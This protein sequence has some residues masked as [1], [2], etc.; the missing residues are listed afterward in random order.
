MAAGCGPSASPGPPPE[1]VLAQRFT[2][3]WAKG[4][5]QALGDM[6][7]TLSPAVASAQTRAAFIARYQGV[8]ERMALTGL[9]FRIGSPVESGAHASVPVAVRYVTTYAGAF[10]EDVR[11]NFTR[12]S[13]G[14]AID[15]AP[16]MILP[17]LAGDRH[18]REEH[19]PGHRGRILT[20]DGTE[21]AL[22]SDQG[23][24]V[25]VVR[26]DIKDE[27]AM[28]AAMSKLLS[29]SPEAIR[30][31]YQGGQPEWFMPVRALPPDTSLNLHNQLS[32]IPGVTVHQA[33]VRFYPQHRAAAQLVGYVSRAGEAQAGLE[34]TLDPVLAGH[35]GGRIFVVDG[36]ENDVGTV[37]QRA[38]APGRDVVLTISW[39]V[40]QAAERA[41]E[42]DPRDAVVAE[43]PRTGDI[44]AMA[45][46]PSFDPNDFA[47]TRND[48]IAGYNAEAASPLLNRATSGQYPSGSTFKPITAAAALRAGVVT[49]DERIPCPHLW[50][51]YG[52]PG[53]E[54]HE[55]ADLGPIDL[56]TAVA[57]SCNTYFYELGKRL[58][59]KAPNLLTD[60][61]RSFGLGA[62]THLPFVSEE[63]GKVPT[64]TAGGEAVNL[65]IGQGGLQVTP[66]QMADYTAA[67]AAAGVLPRPRVVLREEPRAGDVGTGT[68]SPSAAAATPAAAP[69]HALVRP[70]DLPVLLDAMRLVTQDPSG[71]LFAA[72]HGS[73]QVFGKSGTAETTAGNPDI[74][75]IGGAPLTGSS[76][77]V[78]VLV[79]EKP[80]GLH[81][82]DAA[83]IGRATLEAALRAPG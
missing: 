72:F 80:N 17:Q 50:T 28:L 54:N 57:R 13:R 4:D 67:L 53:Q 79:E 71:T 38:A 29:M 73:P 36:Q 22:S 12:G 31:A 62:P 40:Q 46:H 30:Q 58:F 81:T 14:W 39:P 55:S 43:D 70:Q 48:A 42:V 8:R 52:P 6:Y 33:S 9:S 61:A 18:L 82:L 76:A 83:D 11:L 15:W 75:F 10:T 19:L 49:A 68:P 69:A 41:M 60:M 16:E 7:S 34:K 25:G 44:L 21:L 37:V 3:D 27:A 66:L 74:W 24:L 64:L 23:L 51:G 77:V 63:A 45:S 65:A 47:Y 59:Q 2:A 1:T 20:R 78:S 32:A 5:E 26:Q 35:P 56:R